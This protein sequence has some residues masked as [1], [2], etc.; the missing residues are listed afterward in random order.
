M[1]RAAW[2]ILVSAAVCLVALCGRGATA[3]SPAALGAAEWTQWG[4]SYAR[5]MIAQEKNLPT[6]FD[7]G[8]EKPQGAGAEAVPAGQPD[9]VVRWSARLGTESYGNPTVA[10]GR[11]FVGT[12]N[13]SLR[14]PRITGDR[15]VVMCFDDATG[16]FLWQLV[17]PKMPEKD[18]FNGD[19]QGLGICSSPTVDGDRV[20][21]VTNR[22]EIVCLDVK[23][24][25]DGNDG[26]YWD[27]AQ[28]MAG[29][30]QP[31]IQPGPKDGDILWLL[32]MRK[33]LNIWPQDA[34]NCSV[35]VLG[36]YL[37]ACTSNGVDKTHAHIPSP[38]APSFIVL[39][40]RTGQLVA[41]D[42]TQNG[43]HFF[44]GNWSN[45]SLGRVGDRTLI[46]WGG[47]DGICYAFD[48]EPG[49][50]QDDGMRYLKTVWQYDVN[51]PERKQHKYKHPE[52]P[53]EI[54]A[55][56]VF[57]KDRVYVDVGQD[58]LHGNGVGNLACI[59]A[60][61]TGDITGTGTVWACGTIRRSL[62]TISIWDGLL[63]VADYWGHVRCLDADTGREYWVH[64]LKTRIW[65]STLAAD[66]KVYIGTEKKKMTVFAASKELKVLAEFPL[67][68]KMYN[69]PIAVNGRLYVATNE[70]LFVVEKRAEQAAAGPGQG[71]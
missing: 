28:H 49:P 2:I 22:C 38:E 12:N 43:P 67:G 65:S 45:P 13:G 44:H 48:P 63:F 29:P 21:C 37:Y 8:I 18:N 24:M 61:K 36:D 70:R 4:G 64:D 55:T 69:T 40:K 59:D 27:E 17:V 9:G 57:Y 52:G 62:S 26:P 20:Y 1:R 6:W 71:E 53:S 19:H 46:F 5:N 68:A 66:G 34:C 30:G 11:V 25:A 10:G 39:D 7:A 3:A 15:S 14:D 51:P 58:P 56:P 32:D 33:E 35:L 47:G 16:E 42:A 23:G 60:T 54:I 31:P 41:R 50:A